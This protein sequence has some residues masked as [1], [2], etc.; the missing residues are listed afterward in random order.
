MS[1]ICL[2][3]LDVCSLRKL[4]FLL[5]ARLK[6]QDT[7][8]LNKMQVYILKKSYEQAAQK[9]VGKGISLRMVCTHFARKDMQHTHNLQKAQAV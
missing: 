9:G 7:R 8:N 6:Y 3:E 5:K 1:M 4:R 2:W